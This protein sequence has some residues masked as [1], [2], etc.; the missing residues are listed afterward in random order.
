MIGATL[1]ERRMNQLLH[2]RGI[3][4]AVVIQVVRGRQ[5][6]G[7]FVDEHL[8]VDDVHPGVAVDIATE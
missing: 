4:F 5:D 1:P 2:V 6:A 8:Y 3:D 7:G